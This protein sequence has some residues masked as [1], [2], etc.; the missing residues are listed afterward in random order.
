MKL[1][2][3]AASLCVLVS[4]CSSSS[5]SSSTS[6]AIRFDVADL[7]GWKAG[8]SGGHGPDATWKTQ[9]DKGAVSAPNVVSLTTSN[10]TSEDRY[11]VFWSDR[12]RFGDGRLSV[13]VRADAGE[14]DQ[15]GGPIWRAKDA[16]NYY[17]CRFNPLESNYR[18]YVVEDGVRRQLATAMVKV[19]VGEWHRL[20][21]EHIGTQI[22]CWLDGKKLL[23]AT[24]VT[25]PAEGG[26]G[27]W[28]K[29]DA[30]TS[31]DDLVVEPR[32]P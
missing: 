28:T 32:T 30:R 27:L 25:H 2:L 4:A 10:H 26:V 9:E 3:A 18:V 8:S 24:D 16:N 20:E 5:T 19:K 1:Q 22:H 12:V 17:I 29:A 21:V 6:N 23:E 7:Q 14:I 15:G 31:F 13:S 11:N